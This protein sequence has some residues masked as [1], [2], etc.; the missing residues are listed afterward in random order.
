MAGLGRCSDLLHDPRR[1]GLFANPD[2]Y[3]RFKGVVLG[4][5]PEDDHAGGDGVGHRSVRGASAE[6]GQRGQGSA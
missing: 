6:K 4:Y 2:G 5:H 1:A 3:H